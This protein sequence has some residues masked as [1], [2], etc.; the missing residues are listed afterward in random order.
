VI[1]DMD[2]YRPLTKALEEVRAHGLR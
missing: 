1:L 2:L